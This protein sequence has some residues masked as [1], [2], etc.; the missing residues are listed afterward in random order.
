MDTSSLEKESGP[1]PEVRS[2]FPTTNWG[3]VLHAGRTDSVAAA[4]ALEKLCRA[5]WYPL[6]VFI[7]RR[8]ASPHDA[9]DLTQGFFE[10]LFEHDALR[11]LDRERGRFRSFLIAALTNFLNHEFHREHA[12]KRG[13]GRRI[14]SWDQVSAEDRY[15]HEPAA[16]TTP[17]QLF[18]RRWAYTLLD[19]ALARLAEESG[20]AGKGALFERLQGCLT[21]ETAPGFFAETAAA[22]GMTEGAV[23]VALHRLRRR[24]GELLRREVAYTVAGPEDIEEEIRHL[25]KA[26]AS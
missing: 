19:T 20:E 2:S 24:F 8:G 17:A 1:D 16:P 14:V 9:E 5:Y 26:L 4:P 6:Y 15:V 3:S 25:F 10:H 22:L 11:M 21:R 23:K 13:G 12:R 18:E 7:R